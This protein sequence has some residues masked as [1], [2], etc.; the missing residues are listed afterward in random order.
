[1]SFVTELLISVLMLAGAACTLL[2]A[3]GIVRMPDLYTRLQASSKAATLGAILTLSA[4]GIHY[5]GGPVSIKAV[6]VILFLALTT[7]VGAHCIARAA[8]SAG[9][10]MVDPGARDEW[11]QDREGVVTR[12]GEDGVD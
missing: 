1:M 12:P 11:A 10:R 8:Y 6:V 3:V 9:E 4:V 7:P 5:G 2:A